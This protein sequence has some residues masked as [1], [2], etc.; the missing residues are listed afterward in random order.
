MARPLNNPQ[1]QVQ[2]SPR[3]KRRTVEA[4]AAGAKVTE[5]A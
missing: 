3:P 1:T 5:A 2:F 4:E